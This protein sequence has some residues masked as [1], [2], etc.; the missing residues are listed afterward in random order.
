MDQRTL[1]GAPTPS[2]L[3]NLLGTVLNYPVSDLPTREDFDAWLREQMRGDPETS[4]AP[5]PEAETRE[6]R[7]NR[8]ATETGQG[9]LDWLT[10]AFAVTSILRGSAAGRQQDLMGKQRGVE[11]FGKDVMDTS[12][13]AQPR[14]WREML[15]EDLD[16]V[17]RPMRSGGGTGIPPGETP[18]WR[19]GEMKPADVVEKGRWTSRMGDVDAYRIGTPVA[20]P[21][22]Q[23]VQY[24]VVPNGTGAS[25]VLDTGAGQRQSVVFS[26]PS[27][28]E[29]LAKARQLANRLDLAAKD[30]EKMSGDRQV[31]LPWEH[32]RRPP[33]DLIAEEGWSPVTP[34]WWRENVG[35][36]G[37]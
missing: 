3:G 36:P 19:T 27:M 34:G 18:L 31:R 15:E 33:R 2:L 13:R 6:E 28:G 9:I 10:N 23:Q 7:Q 30:M 35:R 16:P 22:G 5:L 20:L 8:Q 11:T 14:K 17:E 29:A 24:V 26:A 32:P 21:G 25:V 4:I 37:D 12:R 1:S